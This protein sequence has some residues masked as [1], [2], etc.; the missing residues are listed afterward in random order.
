MNNAPR[1]E[2]QQC[3]KPSPLNSKDRPDHRCCAGNGFELVTEEDVLTGGHELHSIHKHLGWSGLLGVRLNNFRIDVL[4][5]EAV[6]DEK[7]DKP[8]N[9]DIQLNS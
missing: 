8:Y 7:N 2:P 6:T 9:Y 4:G 5:I 1:Q 3:R